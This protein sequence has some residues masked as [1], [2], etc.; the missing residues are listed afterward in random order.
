M[1]SN[2]RHVMAQWTTNNVNHGCREKHFLCVGLNKMYPKFIGSLHFHKKKGPR[3]PVN[4]C[5]LDSEVKTC[6]EISKKYIYFGFF[7]YDIC[8]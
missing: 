7:G 1:G 8:N 4:A 2:L 3:N 5:K 6:S